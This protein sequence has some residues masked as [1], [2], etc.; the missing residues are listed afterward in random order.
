MNLRDKFRKDWDMK[1]G[2]CPSII[3]VIKIEN[4]TLSLRFKYHPFKHYGIEQH[5]HGTVLCCDLANSPNLCNDPECGACGITRRGFDPLRIGSICKVT[6]QC[7]TMVVL[8]SAIIFERIVLKPQ[9]YG[10]IDDLDDCIDE[11]T[12]TLL[13][14][15][16][17]LKLI[18]KVHI[19]LGLRIK[20]HNTYTSWELRKKFSFLCK[21]LQFLENTLD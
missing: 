19:L 9:R 11:G 16:I 10:R 6:A 15:P 14:S 17:F 8:F 18:T 5:Y 1:N 13:H 21:Y 2:P 4:S 20:L 7:G 12:S 3:A